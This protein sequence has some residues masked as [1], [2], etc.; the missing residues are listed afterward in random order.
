MIFNDKNKH[1]MRLVITSKIKFGIVLDMIHS[2]V[3]TAAIYSGKLMDLEQM[4]WQQQ[5]HHF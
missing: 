1:S 3:T 4:L 2:F 5:C